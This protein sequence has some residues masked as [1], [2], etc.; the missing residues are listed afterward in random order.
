MGIVCIEQPI[1]SEV[2]KKHLRLNHRL[3][4]HTHKRNIS[5]VKNYTDNIHLITQDTSL[6]ISETC[7]FINNNIDYDVFTDDTNYL[8]LV[9]NDNHNKHIN[10]TFDNIFII[11]PSV[12]SKLLLQQLHIENISIKEY[13]H[14]CVELSE[15]TTQLQNIT[16]IDQQI[17]MNSIEL[18]KYNSI[19]PNLLLVNIFDRSEENMINDIININQYLG[20][21]LC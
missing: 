2:A 17:L 19:P 10:Y 11:R 4:A 8:Y 13:I 20:I 12:W 21:Q 1:I 3:Y 6:I 18:K 9:C 15:D 14:K 16:I 7:V 5:Y